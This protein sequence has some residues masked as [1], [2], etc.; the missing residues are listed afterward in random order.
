MK[1]VKSKN[2]KHTENKS[3]FLKSPRSKGS[4]VRGTSLEKSSSSD[5]RLRRFR[6]RF[7]ETN[8]F[9]GRGQLQRK[10]NLRD[11]K[12]N[13]T[14]QSFQAEGNPTE[15][16][17]GGESRIEEDGRE[18]NRDSTRRDAPGKGGFINLKARSFALIL[19]LI[20][21]FSLS[22]TESNTTVYNNQLSK[23]N[24]L[25]VNPIVH[26]ETV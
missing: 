13:F 4:K 5:A 3:T 24:Y 1:S 26:L 25:Y 18:R 19:K 21:I 20:C 16:R 2:F 15:H 12:R 23:K 6:K 22:Q 9:Q 17:R 11:F 8:A 7:F 10:E 14:Q